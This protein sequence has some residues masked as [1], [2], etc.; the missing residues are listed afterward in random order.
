MSIDPSALR[1]I[2]DSAKAVM[3]V[4][5]AQ[6]AEA[7]RPAGASLD[8]RLK[9]SL[10]FSCLLLC[11]NRCPPIPPRAGV[12]TAMRY[13]FGQCGLEQETRE[14]WVDGRQRPVEPQVFD[15]LLLLVQNRER[16]VSQ[17]ELIRGVWQN[18]IVSDSAIAARISAARSAIGDDGKRQAWI[19]T[20]P[21]RGFR[22]VGSIEEEAPPQSTALLHGP[23]ETSRQRVALCRSADGTSIA[24]ATSGSGYP[25]V[26]AGH[27]LT[28][29]EHD[30]Q[31]PIWRPSLD[32]LNRRFH[33]VR[34]DQ[35]GNGLSD[36]TLTDCSL[37]R[38][39]DDLEAVVDAAGLDRFAL[40]GTSQ[41]API[42]IAYSARHPN[43][44]S[45]LVLQGGFA[46]GRLVRG[47]QSEREQAE[48]IITLIR[49]GWAKRGSPFI[50]AFAAMF[51]PD[52][53][54]EQM[55][56]LVNLQRLTTSP[57]NAALLRAAFD[58]FDV[59]DLL[60]KVR[61]STLVIHARD[62]GVQPFDQG[63]RLAARI[64]G[65]EFVVLESGNHMTLPQEKAWPVLFEEIARFVAGA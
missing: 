23:V 4:T 17:D 14:L 57:E 60:E 59:S 42:A 58:S 34:Y 36:W 56:S 19:R 40:Y 64:P 9:V 27:W 22:F 13:R 41:G 61:V 35:R 6:R 32:M 16:V 43:R 48:A 52:G 20:V 29:L 31:S 28:H 1:R 10:S 44:V 65:A 37:E 3:V 26:K 63:R 50:N 25:L 24:Y 51:I 18:R 33:L 39:V 15:L 11:R 47:T 21:R 49:H 7:N 46:Q 30:W 45:R 5:P 62:D 2:G 55:D 54:R 53:S 12:E 38:F 8:R